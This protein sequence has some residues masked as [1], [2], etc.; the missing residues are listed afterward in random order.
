VKPP[1][2][3]GGFDRRQA[4]G[5][6]SD[7][8]NAHSE[9]LGGEGTMVDFTDRIKPDHAAITT[10]L[11]ELLG[12][13]YQ[14]PTFQRDVVWNENQV[15]RL[16]D[17]IF[18]FYPIGSILIWRTDIKLHNHREIGGFIIEQ[19]GD[20][21]EYQYLLD[22]Q[23][24]TTA[25][26]TS[27][28]GGKIHGRDG[29]DPTL[30]VDLTIA[31]DDDEDDDDTYR[32]RFLF[33]TDIDD[34]DGTLIANRGRMERYRKGLIVKLKDVR[35]R[36][37]DLEGAL[38]ASGHRFNDPV[39]GSLRRIKSVLD[40]YRIPFILL[41]GIRVSEVCQI[42]ERVNQEGQPLNIFD[43][44]VAKTYRRPDGGKKYPGFYL[45]EKFDSLRDDLSGSRFALVDD[46]TILQVV[47]A[48]LSRATANSGILNITD[49]YLLNLKA[50]Q[51][52]T[53]WPATKAAIKKAYDFLDNILGLASP[54]L[55]PSRYFYITLAA[56]FW[57]N[58]DPDYD[59]LKKYFWYFSFHNEDLLSNTT[60]VRQHLNALAR[61]EAKATHL[62]ADF[63]I[64]KTALRAASYT[65]RGRLSRAILAFLAYH[66]PKDWAHPFRDIHADFYYVLTDK[67]NLHHVFPVNFIANHS[68]KNA[69]D[70]NSLMNIAYLTQ[71]TNLGISDKNPISY[72]K[73]FDVP[74]FEEILT[75]HV[76]PTR[77]LEWAR[78]AVMPEDALDQFVEAR[79]ELFVSSLKEQL[80]GIPFDVFESKS[81]REI[82]KESGLLSG[83]T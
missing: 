44:V 74:G 11:D 66:R 61:K 56:Y 80:S 10:Y 33:W 21:K 64:D 31:A 13:K 5:S 82:L 15:K 62:M 60:Q 77:I 3:G 34:R 27:I 32:D 59:A 4:C 45:R 65:A 47:A 18:R 26:L 14:I 25:L 9:P 38:D 51:I 57:S 37:G 76:I 22:G 6:A 2:T 54:N 41:R 36:T 29:F 43:I 68:G 8:F 40:N 12:K 79:A 72:I 23:Q 63:R 58:I 16:W 55:I 1:R 78:E 19:V 69:V 39:R 30:Y 53:V 28:Y 49:R 48:V 52:E 35:T 75:S 71:L 83:E 73:D 24:R 42:F 50:D 67:P 17:S 20:Q 81:I 46:Q 70:V 7:T